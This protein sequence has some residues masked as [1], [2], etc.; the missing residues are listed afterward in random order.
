[1]LV[2][3]QQVCFRRPRS[4]RGCTALRRRSSDQ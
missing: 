1:L 3:V 4:G 2:P